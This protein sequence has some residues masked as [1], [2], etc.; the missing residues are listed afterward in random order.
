MSTSA[1]ISLTITNWKE[2]HALTLFSRAFF[3]GGTSL[4]QPGKWTAPR[5]IL[6]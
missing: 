4:T 2:K 5:E 1:A 3:P 6:A